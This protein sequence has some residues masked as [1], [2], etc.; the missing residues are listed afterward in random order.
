MTK[1]EAIK[2]AIEAGL[3]AIKHFHAD[4]K[5]VAAAPEL[6]AYICER[7]ESTLG[8]TLYRKAAELG[9]H[10]TR[11]EYQ[12]EPSDVRHA[13]GVFSVVV[14]DVYSLFKYS[15]PEAAS[16]G[17][18]G[19]ADQS[20]EGG[21]G[22]QIFDHM[23]PLGERLPEHVEALAE[24]AKKASRRELKA[25]AVDEEA[26]G[27]RVHSVGERPVAHHGEKRHG[28]ARPTKEERQDDED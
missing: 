5:F 10:D 21:M 20:G 15:E 12:H 25:E 11:E 19:M 14:W 22:E 17:L 8:E 24:G 26:A 16:L 28:G 2:R 3:S 27:K 6:A 18:P 13:Y 7:G 4:K 9:V 23:K 1:D